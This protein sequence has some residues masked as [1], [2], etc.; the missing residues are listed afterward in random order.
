MATMMKLGTGPS[1][2]NC[3]RDVLPTLLLPFSR[4]RRVLHASWPLP[5]PLCYAGTFICY[6]Y[7]RVLPHSGHQDVPWAESVPPPPYDRALLGSNPKTT[8][9]KFWLYFCMSGALGTMAITWSRSS[10]DP[11]LVVLA[12]STLVDIDTQSLKPFWELNRTAVLFFHAG[13]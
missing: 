13:P 2:S 10:W 4:P 9:A 1:P 6:V 12:T 8:P 7:G 5:P 3:P 11:F